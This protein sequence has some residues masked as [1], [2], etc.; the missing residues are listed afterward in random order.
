[1]LQNAH[2]KQ[3]QLEKPNDRETRG[4][5]TT[6][7]CRTTQRITPWRRPHCGVGDHWQTA[8]VKYP[9]DTEKLETISD[10][11]LLSQGRDENSHFMRVDTV[12]EPRDT[13]CSVQKRNR[14]SHTA[15]H[16]VVNYGAEGPEHLPR[17]NDHEVAQTE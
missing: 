7:R 14:S 13:H 3:L 1:M 6:H 10:M 16:V 15:D 11:L 2:M 9:T 17:T 4:S 8:V 12:R 5:M